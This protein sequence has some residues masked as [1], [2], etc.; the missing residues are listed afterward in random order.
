MQ[1]AETNQLFQFEKAYLFEAMVHVSNAYKNFQKQ[2]EVLRVLV[3]GLV[4]Q[5]ASPEL[6]Q[7]TQSPEN[8]ATFL[9]LGAD[10]TAQAE[11]RGQVYDM[12]SLFTNVVANSRLPRKQELRKG[13]FCPNEGVC[14]P[15]GPYLLQCL[16]VSLA[17]AA[18]IHCLWLP[19]VRSALPEQYRAV[20]EHDASDIRNLLSCVKVADA[21]AQREEEEKRL[22]MAPEAAQAVAEVR[23]VQLWL[24]SMRSFAYRIFSNS[25]GR[26]QGFYDQVT[27]DVLYQAFFRFLDT[28]DDIHLRTFFRAPFPPL[29][30]SHSLLTL[31]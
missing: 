8:L 20:L 2:E 19:Q 30:L 15:S 3:G 21:E 12:F 29:P 16:P 23:R 31:L 24:T 13:G 6:Q 26:V 25:C 22:A 9:G 27:P 11:V 18:A 4:A 17:L 5:I 7:I 14:H 10:I 28:F 1:L